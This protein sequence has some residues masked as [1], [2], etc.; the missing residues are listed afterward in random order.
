MHKSYDTIE[1]DGI[2]DPSKIFELDIEIIKN[3]EVIKKFTNLRSF[4]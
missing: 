4:I 3:P 1:F 2:F